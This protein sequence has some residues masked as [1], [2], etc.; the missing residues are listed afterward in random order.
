M[1]KE[2]WYYRSMMTSA[3]KNIRQQGRVRENVFGSKGEVLIKTLIPGLHIHLDDVGISL[4][5]DNKIVGGP[6]SVIGEEKKDGKSREIIL[7][8][9]DGPVTIKGKSVFIAMSKRGEV[10]LIFLDRL[11]ELKL[12]ELAIVERFGQKTILV[13]DGKISYLQPDQVSIALE[14]CRSN[15]RP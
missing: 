4:C 11:K 8:P 6:V 1:K 3:G 14:A 12:E 9:G 15:H 2:F 7:I 10:Q 13:K 5:L